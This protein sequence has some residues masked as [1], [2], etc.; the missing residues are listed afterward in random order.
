MSGKEN[1][2]K[3]L[4]EPLDI[5][6]F[7]RTRGVPL[8]THKKM[9]EKLKEDLAYLSIPNLEVLLE[10]VE[11]HGGGKL[12]NQY[13]PLT[14]VRSWARELQ[15]PPV[16]EPKLVLSWLRSVEGPKALEGGYAVELRAYLLKFKRP[17]GD[18]ALGEIKR[19]ASENQRARARI[20]ERIA[21]QRAS[22]EDIAWV[23][24]YDEAYR[25]C[26]E[27]ITSSGESAA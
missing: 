8:A 10:I 12:K 2:K 23:N 4:I 21:A 26:V 13:P 20:N 7:T 19:D 14:S 18:Y 15:P 22:E 25:R 24:W 16:S 11:A 1:V 5:I 9:I 27:I 6:G 17:V 3:Y